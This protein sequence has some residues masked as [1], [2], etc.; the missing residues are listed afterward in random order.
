MYVPNSFFSFSTTSGAPTPFILR[1]LYPVVEI[2]SIATAY[3]FSED[4]NFDKADI[5]R[6]KLEYFFF[7]I[8]VKIKH[9]SNTIQRNY[10][11]MNRLNYIQYCT[12][13]VDR[14]VLF[15]KLINL[16]NFCRIAFCLLV[17][18][19]FNF[20]IFGQFI[21]FFGWSDLRVRAYGV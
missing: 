11:K 9:Y 12:G 8:I 14:P 7:I 17:I 1:G 21:K 20:V 2:M 16:H 5:Y 15:K 3:G 19:S 18:K 10:K 13:T 6:C 4:N